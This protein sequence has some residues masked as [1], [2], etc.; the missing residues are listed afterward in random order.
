MSEIYWAYQLTFAHGSSTH[1][2]TLCT[3]T[4]DGILSVRS[5]RI[6]VNELNVECKSWLLHSWSVLYWVW[7]SINRSASALS[8]VHWR[9]LIGSFHLQSICWQLL[10]LA[11]RNKTTPIGSHLSALTWSM[12]SYSFRPAWIY[13]HHTKRNYYQGA[14]KIKVI[15][16]LTNNNFVYLT[17]HLLHSFMYRILPFQWDLDCL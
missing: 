3:D 11:A 4:L 1:R 2:C 15:K 7:W 17:D 10:R 12:V 16:K 9:K 5:L 6:L 14:R 8:L 13:K